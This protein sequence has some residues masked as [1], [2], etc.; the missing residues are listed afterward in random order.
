MIHTSIVMSAQELALENLMDGNKRYQ[1]TNQKYPHQTVSR[2]QTLLNSQKPF[3]VILSCADSRVPPELIFDQGLG[4]LFVIR[5]AGHVVDDVVLASVEF[6]I[7]VLDVPLVMVLGHT[8]CGVVEATISGGELPGSLSKLAV[9][10]QPAVALAKEQP[11]DLVDNA[12]KTNANMTAEQLLARSKLLKQATDDEQVKI[13]VALY[14]LD[15]GAV[16]LLAR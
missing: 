9:A 8:Q 2:R 11:G 16:E 7:I 6:A 3:A 14:R 15:T 5:V 13:V 10:I 4:D 12:I 1:V